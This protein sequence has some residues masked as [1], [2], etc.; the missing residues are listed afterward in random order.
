M[1][2]KHETSMV[3]RALVS[4]GFDANNL[5]V[6]HGKGTG[7]GWITVSADIR[8]APSCYCS[9]PDAFGRRETC[10]PCKK[11]WRDIYNR[12]IEITLEETGRTGDYDGRIGVNLGFFA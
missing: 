12:I 11:T 3:R 6:K 5:R 8:R 10:E 4:A 1:D 2:R 7:W 9:E